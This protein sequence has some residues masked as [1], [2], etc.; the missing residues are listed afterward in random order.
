MDKERA[1]KLIQRWGTAH[2]NHNCNAAEARRSADELAQ[3][4][5]FVDPGNKTQKKAVKPSSE[6]AKT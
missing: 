4:V 5:E 6:P 2:I 1:V 3:V